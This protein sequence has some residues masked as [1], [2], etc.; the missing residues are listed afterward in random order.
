MEK[1]LYEVKVVI[2]HFTES[3]IKLNVLRGKFHQ[4][5]ELEWHVEGTACHNEFADP[6]YCIYRTAS[7]AST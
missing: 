3:T 7:P 2:A 6:R 1:N 4:E 5:A